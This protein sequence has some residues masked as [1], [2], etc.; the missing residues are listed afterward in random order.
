MS[1]NTILALFIFGCSVSVDSGVEWQNGESDILTPVNLA[2]AQR[3][4][5]CDCNAT[6][7]SMP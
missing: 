7:H 3:P 6:H 2:N 4:L 5:V 1:N